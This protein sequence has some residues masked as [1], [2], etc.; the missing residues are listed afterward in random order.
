MKTFLQ[1]LLRFVVLILAI[2]I[3]FCGGCFVGIKVCEWWVV[4]GWV[5]QYPHDGQ[6]GLGVLT[7]GVG[8][9]FLG[10]GLVI[11]GG[12]WWLVRNRNS[13]EAAGDSAVSEE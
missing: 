13:T 5:R 3:G 4:P 11:A 1:Y 10:V 12:I 2:A 6:L 9:G 8:G 7:Y